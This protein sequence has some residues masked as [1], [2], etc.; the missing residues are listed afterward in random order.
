MLDETG[1][2]AGWHPLIKG[3]ENLP[4]IADGDPG[5]PK[6]FL[7]RL[8]EQERV[9]LSPRHLDAFRRRLGRLYAAGPGG[10]VQAGD[11]ETG[12]GEDESVLGVSLPIPP[13]TFLE[14]LSQ[15]LAIH[16]ISVYW[17]LQELREHERLVCPPET[18]RETED[19]LSVKFLRM[20]GHRW[21]LQ[22]KYEEEEG[23][24]FLDPM[25]VDAD[26]LI[27]LTSDMGEETLSERYRFFLDSEFGS[28]FGHE[29]ELELAHALGWKP[30]T[31]WGKQRPLALG[32][33]FKRD[34][35]R[36]HVSQFKR[37]PIAWH[38]KS[39]K[40]T[41]QLIVYYH[42]FNRDRL[43][44][45][46]ARYLGNL[47]QELDGTLAAATAKGYD[48]RANMVRVEE[49]EERLA[50][51]DAFDANLARLQEGREREARIWCPWKTPEEQPQGW[52]P[53]I[54]DGV[55]VNI[56]PLQRLGLLAADVL[57]KK[58][59]NSLLAPEGQG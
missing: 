43:A 45:L 21:P 30:G 29:V 27:A 33:W 19:W 55:R 58:D 8:G 25:W 41:V 51:L 36:R 44:L 18:K 2:P 6:Q 11:D 9:E 40:G 12:A 24:P 42:A 37:R 3:Y 31:E 53:D 39:P 1:T 10:E 54:N 15:K 28:D 4:E 5:L 34:F 22:D 32:E 7:D 23:A 13:E 16:P 57:N 17:L 49:L 38:L 50:D 52:D 48:D 59:L 35:F 14:G 26:G 47:R 56:A 20:L 46:R